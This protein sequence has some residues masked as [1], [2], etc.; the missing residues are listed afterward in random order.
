M[1][2]Q[3]W[4]IKVSPIG[5]QTLAWSGWWVKVWFQSLSI[6]HRPTNFSLI[7]FE[8]LSS[9]HAY[10]LTTLNNKRDFLRF[11]VIF[12]WLLDKKRREN[13][14]IL[15]FPSVFALSLGEDWQILRQQREKS[16]EFNWR[17]ESG[18]W[19]Y[20]IEYRIYFNLSLVYCYSGVMLPGKVRALKFHHTFYHTL[21]SVEKRNWLFHGAAGLRLWRYF[22]EMNF[23][24]KTLYIETLVK[25]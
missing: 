1:G 20:S 16:T 11:S 8:A 21:R 22:Y 13:C 15:Q 3:F 23:L 10:Y 24:R 9:I 25:G 12:K 2:F 18:G 4:K 19:V 7:Q 5:R 17:I 6:P 14:R